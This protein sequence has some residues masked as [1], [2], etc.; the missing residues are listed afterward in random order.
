MP[1]ADILTEI[2]ATKR[3][4]VA[5]RKFERPVADLQAQFADAGPVRDF[6]AALWSAAPRMGL[7]AEIKKASPSAGLIRPDFDAVSIA[8]TYARHGANCLSVLTDETYFQGHLDYLTAVRNAVQIPVLR[9]DF[10]IDSYQV[11]EARI[12]GADCVLLIAECLDDC[13]LRDLYFYAAELG[14]ES[15]VEIHDAENL[16]RVL[17]LEPALIGI[18]NRDLKVMRTDLE[19]TIRLASKIPASCLLISESGIKSHS[20]VVRL[21]QAGARAM[22]VG[23]SLMKQS[24][25]GHAVD[26]LLGQTTAPE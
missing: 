2:I 10:I 21:Q 4:E 15:L 16:D 3:T 14:M 22:L 24:D 8:Q 26:Q 18:N 11:L 1:V 23:E 25:I 12:A 17:K 9:K 6:A 19:H 20:D 7:I 13:Q 5:A